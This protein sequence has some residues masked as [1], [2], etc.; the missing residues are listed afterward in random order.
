MLTQCTGTEMALSR[1]YTSGKAADP[2]I[3]V[4]TVKTPGKNH[5]RVVSIGP[6]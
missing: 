4:I 2:P 5:C 6:T 1:V 3:T